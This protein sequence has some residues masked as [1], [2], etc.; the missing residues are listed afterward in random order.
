M[1]I[2]EKPVS[3]LAVGEALKCVWDMGANALTTVIHTPGVATLNDWALA[4]LAALVLLNLLLLL[5]RL[6]IPRRAL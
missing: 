5:L 2:C 3:D 1:D 4:V 6:L